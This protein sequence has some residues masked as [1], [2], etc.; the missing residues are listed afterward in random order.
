[1]YIKIYTHIKIT[2]YLISSLLMNN[3]IPDFEN[4]MYRL[5]NEHLVN[6]FTFIAPWKRVQK[7]ELMGQR[8]YKSPQLEIPGLDGCASLSECCILPL[9]ICLY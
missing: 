8:L 3:F 7:E 5:C 6:L 1:M 9:Y 4:S 2:V